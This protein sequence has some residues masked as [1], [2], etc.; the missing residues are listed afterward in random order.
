MSKWASLA[1]YGVSLRKYTFSSSVYFNTKGPALWEKCPAGPALPL[2]L[3]CL[4]C[5]DCTSI[6]GNMFCVFSLAHT[7]SPNY[8]ILFYFET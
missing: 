4:L 3:H 1:L 2:S 8:Y 7:I 6:Q 5:G